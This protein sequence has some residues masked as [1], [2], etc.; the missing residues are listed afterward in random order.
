MPPG[1]G[2]T[3][4]EAWNGSGYHILFEKPPNY[5]YGGGAIEIYLDVTTSDLAADDEYQTDSLPLQ[6]MD[7]TVWVRRMG[8]AMK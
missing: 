7:S 4:R 2:L 8:S 5:Y 6:P 3:K 1:F